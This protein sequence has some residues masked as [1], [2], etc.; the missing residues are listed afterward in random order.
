[1]IGIRPSWG[2]F[3]CSFGYHDID[4][5]T[6]MLHLPTPRSR[7]SYTA[8]IVKLTDEFKQNAAP[9]AQHL[10]LAIT[11]GRRRCRRGLMKRGGGEGRGFP[12][13]RTSISAEYVDDFTGAAPTNLTEWTNV[14]W[15]FSCLV[16]G[17]GTLEMPTI[18]RAY[19]N[20]LFRCFPRAKCTELSARPHISILPPLLRGYPCSAIPLQSRFPRIDR[21]GSAP[22]SPSRFRFVIP[23][24]L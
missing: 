18:L 20:A 16:A 19:P 9:L 5:T 13:S 23:S 1:M 17:K 4:N 14:V 24:S 15:R 21:P 10:C 7:N 2:I 8:A 6:S 3:W 11:A 22:S 12:E